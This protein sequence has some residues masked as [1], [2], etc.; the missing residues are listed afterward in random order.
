MLRK[1]GSTLADN[2]KAY[3]N[4]EVIE[5]L[6]VGLIL[7]GSEVKSLREGKVSL[8]EA[9][10]A[11]KQDELYLFNCTIAEYGGSNRFNHEP[12]RPRKLLLKKRE[13][14][15]LMGVVQKKGVTLIPLVLYF[16]EKGRVKLKLGLARGKTNV[17][18]RQT[19]KERDWNREKQRLLK[20]KSYD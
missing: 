6:E 11:P 18:K 16:N 4:Y 12:K 20:T 7:T 19:L 9:H 15:K 3:F 13:R 10:A 1:N 17:D 14:N 8:G 5:S 2:R